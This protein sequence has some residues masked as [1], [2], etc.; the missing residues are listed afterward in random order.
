MSHDEHGQPR[1][2]DTNNDAQFPRTTAGSHALIS[3]WI[4]VPDG[5]TN[6]GITVLFFVGSIRCNHYIR[7][8]VIGA[9]AAVVVILER[10]RIVVLV[11]V[12]L[13]V[14]RT[15]VVV[16]FTICIVV[17]VVVVVVVRGRIQRGSLR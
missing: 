17:V 14:V 5:T 9:T 10:I 2:Q 1:E 8:V 11:V 13:V 7:K 4:H 6:V 3:R 16:G 15:L 12:V